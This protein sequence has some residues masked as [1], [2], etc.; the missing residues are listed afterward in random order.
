MFS[1]KNKCAQL[2]NFKDC[3]K[4]KCKLCT[5]FFL[6]ILGFTVHYTVHFC[7]FFEWLQNNVTV[8]CTVKSLNF[9]EMSQ[10]SVAVSKCF[11]LK[12]IVHNMQISRIVV[13]INASCAN[14][15]SLKFKI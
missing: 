8:N 6:K 15:L 12:I 14:N 2:A 13:T 9:S 4:Y 11:H 1:V 7:D 3:C 10:N 5:K